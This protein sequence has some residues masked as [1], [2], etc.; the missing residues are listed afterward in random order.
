MCA[1][2]KRRYIW[3][4]HP[5]FNRNPY[6]GYINPYYWVDEFIPYYMEIMGVDRPWHIC[7]VVKTCQDVALR[8][9]CKPEGSSVSR[10]FLCFQM[11]VVQPE[12]RSRSD[13]WLFLVPRKGGIGSIFDPPE[14][15]DEKWY[16]N[17]IFPA[18]WGII[19]HL[20]GGSSHLV[21]G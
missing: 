3:D 15:K 17:G 20:L 10:S 5:T 9:A 18:N 19:C 8:Y 1:M 12:Q 13:Q 2:V 16:I 6:N 14:G 7:H 11:C 21:N 4:G